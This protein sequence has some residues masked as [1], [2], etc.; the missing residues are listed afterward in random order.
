MKKKISLLLAGA[1]LLNAFSLST[2]AS[3]TNIVTQYFTKLDNTLYTNNIYYENVQVPLVEYDTLANAAD[4]AY[5]ELIRTTVSVD[6]LRQWVI[7]SNSGQYK[8]VEGT[9]DP[10]FEKYLPQNVG[11]SATDTLEDASYFDFNGNNIIEYHEAEAATSVMG[12]A[13]VPTGVQDVLGNEITLVGVPTGENIVVDGLSVTCDINLMFDVIEVY[14]D[15][16]LYQKTLGREGLTFNPVNPP[17]NTIQGTSGSVIEVMFEEDNKRRTEMIKNIGIPLDEPK[18]I[19]KIEEEKQGV[20]IGSNVDGYTVGYPDNIPVLRIKLDNSMKSGEQFSVTLFNAMWLEEDLLLPNTYSYKDGF[21]T[22]DVSTTV[23]RIN[24][25]KITVTLQNNASAGDIIDIPIYAKIKGDIPVLAVVN[26][27]TPDVTHGFYFITER[28]IGHIDASGDNG[29]L[30]IDEKVKN[31]LDINE[32]LFIEIIGDDVY[33]DTNQSIEIHNNSEE[34]EVNRGDVLQYTPKNDKT[35]AIDLKTAVFPNIHN[36]NG[37]L[38]IDL[39]D[40]LNLKDKDYKGIIQLYVY[41]AGLEEVN[42]ELVTIY[43]FSNN[44]EVDIDGELATV[45]S[46]RDKEEASTIRIKELAYGV[47]GTERYIKL[48]LSDGAYFSGPQTFELQ[49]SEH[50]QINIMPEEDN[51]NTL[52]ID[53]SK[54]NFAD[55]AYGEIVYTPIIGLE[56]KTKGDIVLTGSGSGILGTNSIVIAEAIAPISIRTTGLHISDYN[57][58]NIISDVIINEEFTGALKTGR[59]EFYSANEETKNKLM[60]KDIDTKII[61]N[62]GLKSE[63]KI[64][65]NKVVLDIIEESESAPAEI[66]IEGIEFSLSDS[67]G[68]TEDPYDVG[69]RGVTSSELQ[70]GYEFDYFTVSEPIEPEDPVEPINPIDPVEPEDNDDDGDDDDDDDGIVGKTYRPIDDED[71]KEYVKNLNINVSITVDETAYEINGE[72]AGELLIAPYINENGSV[73]VPVRAL[74]LVFGVPNEDII[75]N[76]QTQTVT[77]NITDDRVVQFTVG[78]NTCLINGKEY[79]IQTTLGLPNKVEVREE[80]TFLPLRFL[81]EVIYQVKVDWIN[82]KQTA[83]FNVI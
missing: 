83:I 6:S 70:N 3:S 47:L 52:Y 44:V 80:Y 42:K 51:P 63:L 60:F 40:I 12:Y 53:A 41:G 59:Y 78:S 25:H 20:K 69:F 26:E 27:G 62:N 65:D 75:W 1:L 72:Y 54:L 48:E 82:E 79:V 21:T 49:N 61:E 74:S 28:E 17:I 31:T 13:D 30:V 9:V 32:P 39:S 8:L 67:I 50:T 34:F 35:I 45:I 18:L 7:D 66:K 5:Q 56:A 33:W 38:K 46:G 15:N 23:D 76:G 29:I 11:E 68:I 16:D 37:Q 22:G 43:D 58:T 55:G 81:G 4:R 2:L 10:T 73:M 14:F 36:V 71:L 24:N 77:L 64:E 19:E 57:A